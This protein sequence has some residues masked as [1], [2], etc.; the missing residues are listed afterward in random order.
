MAGLAAAASNSAA[1]WAVDT[2]IMEATKVY[3]A[4]LQKKADA[5]ANVPILAS[6]VRLNLPE[7]SEGYN[8]LQDPNSDYVLIP[9]LLVLSVATFTAALVILD[10]L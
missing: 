10:G 1:A 6:L 9:V 7:G 8:F 2:G 5:G 4:E 3:Q